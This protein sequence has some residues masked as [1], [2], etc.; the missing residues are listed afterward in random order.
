MEKKRQE[1]GKDETLWTRDDLEK[2]ER[3]GQ[4]EKREGKKRRTNPGHL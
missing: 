2:K 1:K 3:K 4:E